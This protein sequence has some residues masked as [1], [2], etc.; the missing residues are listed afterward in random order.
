LRF[1]IESQQEGDKSG[2]EEASVFHCGKFIFEIK[3][4]RKIKAALACALVKIRRFTNE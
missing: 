2:Q 1:D 4:W 3:R